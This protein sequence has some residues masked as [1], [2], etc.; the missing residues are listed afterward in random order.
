MNVVESVGLLQ[1]AKSHTSVDS[2]SL[3]AQSQGSY[4]EETME[5]P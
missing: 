4:M 2:Q 1:H 3:R 5:S